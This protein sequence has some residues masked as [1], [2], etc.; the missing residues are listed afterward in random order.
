MAAPDI[1]FF[2][3]ENVPDSVARFIRSKGHEVRLSRDTVPVGSPDPLIA[4]VT[5]QNGWVLVPTIAEV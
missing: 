5:E 3:D 1:S 2:L 4:T